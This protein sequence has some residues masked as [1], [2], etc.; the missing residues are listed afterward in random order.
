MAGASAG[1]SVEGGIRGGAV[2]TSIGGFARRLG[3]AILA[4][5]GWARM[6]GSRGGAAGMSSLE[7]VAES[8]AARLSESGC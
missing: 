3:D 1:V 5:A 4:A 7:V 6:G 2:P 8:A